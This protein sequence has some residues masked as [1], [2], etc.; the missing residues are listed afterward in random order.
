MAT[1][2]SEFRTVRDNFVAICNCISAAEVIEFAGELLR[3]NLISDAAHQAAIAVTD[4]TESPPSTTNKVAHLVSE[5]ANKVSDSPNNFYKFISIVENRNKEL[6]STLRS[7][8]S[9]VDWERCGQ[10]PGPKRRKGDFC[11]DIEMVPVMDQAALAT[12]PGESTAI[13]NSI[14]HYLVCFAQISM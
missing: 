11:A 6:A 5:A 2:S 10:P 14:M 3:S 12:V 7:D 8:Y 4:I 1:E 13:L 9:E